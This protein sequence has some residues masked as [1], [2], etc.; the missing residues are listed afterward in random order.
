MIG[1]DVLFIPFGK[2]PFGATEPPTGKTLE[3]TMQAPTLA[4]LTKPCQVSTSKD[5]PEQ[6]SAAKFETG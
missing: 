6:I 5:S 1:F 4:L 3:K 2:T